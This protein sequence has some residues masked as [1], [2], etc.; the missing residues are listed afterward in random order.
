MN[1]ETTDKEEQQGGEGET[2]RIVNS[3]DNLLI[4]RVNILAR[5]A[6]LAPRFL[7]HWRADATPVASRHDSG[8]QRVS[9]HGL[10]ASMKMFK[11]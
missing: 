2:L 6:A 4:H 9:A 1:L 8:K 10:L 11:K 3:A 7:F 5:G